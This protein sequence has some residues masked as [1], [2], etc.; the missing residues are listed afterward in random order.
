MTNKIVVNTKVVDFFDS[1]M[2]EAE[3]AQ[4]IRR[5]TYLLSK[6]HIKSDDPVHSDWV[7]ESLYYLTD[8]AELIDPQ[9]T[10]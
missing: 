10:K 1:T 7:D 9:L 5:T 2:T 4:I 8:F 6:Y 3:F